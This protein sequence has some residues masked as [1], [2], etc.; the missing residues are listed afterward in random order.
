MRSA[1]TRL[2][3]ARSS[4]C[5][6]VYGEAKDLIPS[7]V[8]LVWSDGWIEQLRFN[9]KFHK[10][11]ETP[12]DCAHKESPLPITQPHLLFQLKKMPCAQLKFKWQTFTHPQLFWCLEWFSKEDASYESN[13]M[14]CIKT[15]GINLLHLPYYSIYCC[16]ICHFRNLSGAV[17]CLNS[18][19]IKDYSLP[20]S[21]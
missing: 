7:R 18:L 12:M 6:S 2:F 9:S 10:I 20:L 17:S 1:R 8:S 16:T 13:S 15:L 14:S 3:K 11:C 5:T 21:K 4:T 19:V